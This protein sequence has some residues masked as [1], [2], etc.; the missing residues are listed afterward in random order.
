[1]FKSVKRILGRN[2]FKITTAVIAVSAMAGLAYAQVTPNQTAQAAQCK[3]THVVYCGITGSDA[4]SNINSFKNY[5][6]ANSTGH[7]ASPTVKRDYKDMHTVFS[8][9]GANGNHVNAMNTENT[10]RGLIHRDGRIEVDGKVV[11]T[12]AYTA[13]RFK[14]TNSVL[15][16]GTN[17]YKRT[18]AESFS[19]GVNALPAI[20]YF[21]NGR[22]VFGVMLDCG[23]PITA[24]PVEVP[25]PQTLV[26]ENLTMSATEVKNRFRF[27]ARAQAA[28]G[29][30]INSYTFDF[31]DGTDAQTVTGSSAAA[32]TEYT[33]AKAGNYTATV[34]VNGKVNNVAVSEGSA[35]CA[36]KIAIETPECRP[37]IPEGDERCEPCPIPGKEDLPKDSADCAEVKPAAVVELPK[38]GPAGAL[39]IFGGVSALSALAHRF[40]AIRRMR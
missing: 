15:V 27:E 1:M 10:K 35:S 36:T 16:P 3:N 20:I 37:G 25:K 12:N 5:Y 6:N 14:T 19:A 39:A 9:F 11:A 18:P 26:C 22:M 33:Y 32:S 2:K 40:V 28:H 8:Y 34:K 29:A 17:V 21:E 31:G 38:A 4:G 30:T 7:A 13:G 23:N 24:T